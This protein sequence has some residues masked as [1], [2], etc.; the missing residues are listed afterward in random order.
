MSAYEDKEKSIIV[1]EALEEYINKS[2][3]VDK[4]KKMIYKNKE[5]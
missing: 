4:E 2:T 1:R 3:S 5:R